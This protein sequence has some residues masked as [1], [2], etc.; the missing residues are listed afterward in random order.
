MG[1]VSSLCWIGTGKYKSQR[2]AE[3]L[4][5]LGESSFPF[6]AAKLQAELS[7][8]FSLRSSNVEINKGFVATDDTARGI[9]AFPLKSI[10][11]IPAY[12]GNHNERLFKKGDRCV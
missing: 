11:S 5:Y 7:Q 9:M 4:N 6:E 10:R 3:Q 1:Q 12:S 2:Q 8:N